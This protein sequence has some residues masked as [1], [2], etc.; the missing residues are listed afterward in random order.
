[1]RACKNKVD[2][3]FKA[4]KGSFYVLCVRLSSHEQQQKLLRN[5][6]GFAK[7]N[8]YIRKM[9]QQHSSKSRENPEK[10][11]VVVYIYLYLST[12]QLSSVCDVSCEISRHKGEL[13][14]E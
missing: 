10:V 12:T 14:F 9:I 2:S 6:T 3:N 4:E 13:G 7:L 8:L 1:M 11:I 5:T